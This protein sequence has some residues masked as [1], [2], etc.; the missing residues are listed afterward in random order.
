MRFP[1]EME[2][3]IIKQQN[4]KRIC[5]CATNGHS[6]INF[7]GVLIRGWVDKGYEVICSSIE[8]EDEMEPLLAPLGAKYIQIAGDRTGIDI[9]SGFRMIRDYC[10]VFREWQPDLCFLYMSKPVAFGGIAA[11]LCRI[12]HINIL[13]NGLE[14]AYY[15]T[16]VKDWVVRCVMSSFYRI[17]SYFADNVFFQ[18]EDD[19]M[20]FRKHH[21]LSKNNATIVHGSGVDMD[22][23]RRETIPEEPVILMVARLLWSKGIREFLEAVKI[24]SSKNKKFRVLLVGG[25]DHN[26]EALSESELQTAIAQ[27]NIEYCGH[28]NDVRPYLK[29]CS[30]FVLPSYHEGLPRSVI[31][32]MAVGRPIITT[33]TPGCRETVEEGVNG[34]LVPARNAEAL[35]EAMEK[36]IDSN[37]LRAKMAE[38]SYRICRNK[39]EVHKVNESMN[40]KMFI[41]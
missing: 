7:R 26:D 41:D 32:A 14:N 11:T 2:G 28:T 37:E 23:F 18:N 21:L 30:I 36:L 35:A 38:E 9:I 16:G 27:S 12:K 17:V 19:M 33:R 13:V 24:V 34:F 10:K 40:Q 3:W 5:I 6:L 22:Y 8:P 25:L 39:F 20:Y 31:E 1:C 4:I 29:K 15:R